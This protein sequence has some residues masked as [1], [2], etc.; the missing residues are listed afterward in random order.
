MRKTLLLVLL[1]AVLI[2]TACAGDTPTPNQGALDDT[3]S[4]AGDSDTVPAR[5]T[6]Q[7]NAGDDVFDGV[8]GAY[9]WF[10]AANDIRC[11][12]GPFDPQPEAVAQ[13]EQGDTLTFAIGSENS[14]PT[15]VS[16][17]LLDDMSD[18]GSPIVIELDSDLATD[19]EVDLDAGM[20]RISVLAEFAATESDTNFITTVF[21]VNV[22]EAV[23]MAPTETAPPPT[24]T[25]E[26][27]PTEA[28]SEEPTEIPATDEPEATEEATE[29]PTEEPT[30]TEPPPTAVPPT[31]TAVPSPTAIPPTEAPAMPAMTVPEVLVVKGSSV[32]QPV[33]TNYCPSDAEGCEAYSGSMPDQQITL[34]SGD[35]VRIDSADGGPSQM[36]FV[37]TNTGQTEEFDRLAIPGNSIALYTVSAEPGTYL[38]AIETTWPDATATYYF[39]LEITG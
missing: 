30:A 19:Y 7:M 8:S 14:I 21:A 20:H 16:A 3:S 33:G 26:P 35:T 5:P 32:F 22:A 1:S 13:V 15:T 29:E 6:I 34:V 37:L 2:L 27:E 25:D 24:A 18:D 38:L 10:Q 36:T 31:A 39:R 17:T 4:P 11:E 12:P 23:A 9:C 28:A